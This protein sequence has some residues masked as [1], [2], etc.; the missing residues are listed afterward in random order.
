MLAVLGYVAV[1]LGL[2]GPGA[3]H[4]SSLLAHDV[5]VKSGQMLLLLNVCALF[6]VRQKNRSARFLHSIVDCWCY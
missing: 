3:P 2:Y 5:T 1:D 4:V 6:E